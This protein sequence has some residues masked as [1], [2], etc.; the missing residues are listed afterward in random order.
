MKIKEENFIL[1]WNLDGYM[2]VVNKTITDNSITVKLN[3][4]I[5]DGN[6]LAVSYNVSYNK[7]LEKSQ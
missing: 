3:E 1:Q 7:K 4:V 2:T 5:L 6:E